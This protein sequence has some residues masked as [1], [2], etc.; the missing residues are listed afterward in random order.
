MGVEWRWQ[1]VPVGAER[2]PGASGPGRWQTYRPFSMQLIS[3]GIRIPCQ[4]LFLVFLVHCSGQRH[5]ALGAKGSEGREV[6]RARKES[7]YWG[8][9]RPIAAWALH[10]RAAHIRGRFGVLAAQRFTRRL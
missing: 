1:P 5:G 4:F 3:F 7:S 10:P 9:C 6:N 2:P 8:P